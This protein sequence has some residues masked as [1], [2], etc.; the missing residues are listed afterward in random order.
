M[1]EGNIVNT[2]TCEINLA[3]KK[4]KKVAKS[5]ITEKHKL[6]S[7]FDEF[8]ITNSYSGDVSTLV[9]VMKHEISWG[10]FIRR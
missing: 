8:P 1:M 7:T 9:D 5:V 4:E 6:F 10:C 3:V 2:M